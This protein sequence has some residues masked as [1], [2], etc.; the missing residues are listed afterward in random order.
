M[1]VETGLATPLR[2]ESP[3]LTEKRQRDGRRPFLS[4]SKRERDYP[5][6]MFLYVPT[7][8]V[9]KIDRGQNCLKI[10]QHV[11]DTEIYRTVKLKWNGS[12]KIRDLTSKLVL[13]ERSAHT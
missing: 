1:R 11:K 3:G 8:F 12:L 7:V 13:L 2:V 6:F 5:H 10:N 4:M 9:Q